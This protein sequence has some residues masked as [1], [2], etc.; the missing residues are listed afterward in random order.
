MSAQQLLHVRELVMQQRR[1]RAD[2]HEQEL[3]LEALRNATTLSDATT[4]AETSMETFVAL[5][6]MFLMLVLML[7]ITY[8][9]W[10]CDAQK[11][12]RRW[13]RIWDQLVVQR[14]RDLNE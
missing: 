8:Q 9:I 2:L 11:T 7:S 4:V 1:I 13:R 14:E 6:A 3:I 10:K 12:G 5:A